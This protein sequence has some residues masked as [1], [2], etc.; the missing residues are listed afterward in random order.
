MST[1]LTTFKL[2]HFVA[3]GRNI[4]KPPFKISDALVNEARIVHVVHGSSRL[5]AIKN[6]IELNDG[7]TF[8]MKA[9]N[10][11]NH[12]RENEDEQAN[13]VIV[14]QLSSDLLSHVFSNNV[15]E[16]L[17]QNSNESNSME[18][19]AQN[20]FVD[21]YFQNLRL[22]FDHPAMMTED[23]LRQK[24]TELILL[25]IR[26]DQNGNIKKI[27]SNLF[28]TNELSFKEL[29]QNN[30]YNDLNLEELAFMAGTSLS[31][32][33]RRFTSIYGTS[34]NKY[35]ISKRLEKAQTLLQT[36]GMNIGQVAFDCGFSDEGYFTK[37]FKKFYN[38]TP[39][40]FKNNMVN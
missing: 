18:K 12:W 38:S 35:F 13:E 8:I 39:S 10:F 19:V 34:P 9:D 36:T 28:D 22:Y 31:S 23:L 5:Y 1:N 27:F 24:I 20:E 37:T 30:L 15:P 33:K 26:T 14:F 6:F 3:C 32:F 17:K 40:E 16:S 25:L 4:F 21:A 2:A 29:I 7:D 11:V